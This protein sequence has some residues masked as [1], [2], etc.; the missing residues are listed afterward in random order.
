MAEATGISQQANINRYLEG[1]RSFNIR[2][3]MENLEKE[4][5]TVSKE[6][7]SVLRLSL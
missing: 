6:S 1:D 3:H 2:N 5:K 7:K 4:E